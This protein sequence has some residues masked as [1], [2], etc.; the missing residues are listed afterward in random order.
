MGMQKNQK[1]KGSEHKYF[2]IEAIKSSTVMK[3]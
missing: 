1:T 2:I 3:L